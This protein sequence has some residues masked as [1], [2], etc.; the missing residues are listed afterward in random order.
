VSAASFT[1]RHEDRPPALARVGEA[2]PVI[3]QRTH[4]RLS[5]AVADFE[6]TVR[7]ARPGQRI[8]LLARVEPYIGPGAS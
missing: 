1:L 7:V 2:R 8:E 4:D 6:A 3:A 5:A